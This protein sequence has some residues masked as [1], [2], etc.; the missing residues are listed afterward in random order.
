MAG[1]FQFMGRFLGGLVRVGPLA[2]GEILIGDTGKLPAPKAISGD[3]TLA[4]TGALT[5][6]NG[7]ITAPMLAA[8]ALA[9]IPKVFAANVNA[10]GTVA[11]GGAGLT[12]TKT[13][14]GAYDV[15]VNSLA[16]AGAVVGSVTPADLT[17]NYRITPGAGKVTVNTDLAGAADKAF[18]VI[19]FAV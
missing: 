2:D 10:D 8:D 6:G 4:K 5:I 1:A 18:S 13:G 19:V 17:T 3:A 11:S 16:G 15:A 9:L 14:T 7:K 12:V